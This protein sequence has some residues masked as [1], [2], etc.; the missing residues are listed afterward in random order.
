MSR[1]RQSKIHSQH[2]RVILTADEPFHTRIVN[3]ALCSVGQKGNTKYASVKSQ[4]RQNVLTT[5]HESSDVDALNLKRQGNYR[6][7]FVFCWFTRLFKAFTADL[8]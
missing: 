8:R 3:K 4:V 1:S 5:F 2:I 6:E 7:L